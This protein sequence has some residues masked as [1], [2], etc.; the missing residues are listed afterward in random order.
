MQSLY[1]SQNSAVTTVAMQDA[2][3]DSP[4]VRPRSPYSA[5]AYGYCLQQHQSMKK[6]TVVCRKDIRVHLG[7]LLSP[8]LETASGL[9]LTLSKCHPKGEP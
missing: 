7:N 4:V 6:L 5:V 1:E 9:D 3:D 8:V 2:F